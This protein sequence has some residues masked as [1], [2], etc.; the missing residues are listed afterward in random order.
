MHAK[1]KSVPAAAPSLSS[2]RGSRFFDYFPQEGEQQ[3]GGV[4]VGLEG[5]GRHV[6]EADQATGMVKLKENR[7]Q[8]ETLLLFVCLN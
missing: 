5:G 3:G 7:N 2:S 8:G 4:G 1:S 6:G